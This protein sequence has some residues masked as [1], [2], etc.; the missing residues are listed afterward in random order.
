MDFIFNSLTKHRKFDCFTVRLE[1]FDMKSTNIVF[2]S[3]E[4]CLLNRACVELENEL[5]GAPRRYGVFRSNSR[6]FDAQSVAERSMSALYQAL[7]GIRRFGAV[8]QL[9]VDEVFSPLQAVVDMQILKYVKRIVGGIGGAWDESEDTETVLREGIGAGMF[10]GLDS[11]VMNFRQFYGMDTMF[12]YEKLTS[13]REGGMKNL[14]DSAREELQRILS[15]N[16]F[17][18][19]GSALGEIDRIAAEGEK[20]LMGKE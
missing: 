10:L 2:G 11:T 13:W 4:W 8:G 9:C 15:T 16:D 3:P 14:D 5:R 7:N 1:P 6:R 19:P 20:Y 17:R 12:T 18:L